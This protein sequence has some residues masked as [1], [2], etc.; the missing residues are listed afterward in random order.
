MRNDVSTKRFVSAARRLLSEFGR[1]CQNT[2]NVSVRFVQPLRVV[3]TADAGTGPAGTPGDGVQP[4][5]AEKRSTE[6]HR[7]V[8]EP[9]RSSPREHHSRPPV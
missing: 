6:F 7:R 9:R 4:F 1:R 3:R 5:S 2:G 8:F